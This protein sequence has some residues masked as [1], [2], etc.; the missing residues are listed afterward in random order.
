MRYS[1]G[2]SQRH[3][4]VS[5][6]I[7]RLST[8]VFLAV[9]IIGKLITFLFYFQDIIIKTLIV[10]EPHVLHSYRLCRPGSNSTSPSVCF[11]VLGFDILLD[12]KMKPWLL[13]VIHH[14]DRIIEKCK[15]QNYQLTIR[16]RQVLL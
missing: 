2:Y 1:K 4:S 14:S 10:S 15:N 6:N 5:N 13:E 12:G 7:S 9:F 3:L 8:F 16:E 11:E